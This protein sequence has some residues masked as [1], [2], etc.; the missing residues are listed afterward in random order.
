MFTPFRHPRAARTRRL[1]IVS[2]AI[3]P[4]RHGS[5]ETYSAMIFD[6]KR[7]RRSISARSCETR[8]APVQ[9]QRRGVQRAAISAM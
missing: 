4:V 6:L 9:A 1:I 3:I 7:A 2:V 8:R 5:V